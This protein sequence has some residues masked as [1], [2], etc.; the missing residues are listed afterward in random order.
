MAEGQVPW[1]SAKRQG[2]RGQRPHAL[3]RRGARE[4][5]RAGRLATAAV[6]AVSRRTLTDKVRKLHVAQKVLALGLHETVSDTIE[7]GWRE[8]LAVSQ[9]GLQVSRLVMQGRLAT[10]SSETAAPK[11]K[12]HWVPSP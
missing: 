9:K 7:P 12:A 2:R 11:P 10:S 3:R 1:S 5:G 4:G 6:V 8:T